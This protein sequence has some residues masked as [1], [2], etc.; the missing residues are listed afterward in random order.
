MKINYR[1]TALHWLK[2]P[3]TMEFHIPQSKKDWG[4][5]DARKFGTSMQLLFA[6]AVKAG[7]YKKKIR[8]I[9]TPFL[10]AFEKGK[11]ALK[12]VFDKEDID[13]SGTF[14]TQNGSWTST[15]FY[16]VRTWHCQEGNWNLEFSL[17]LFTKHA[18]ADSFGLDVFIMHKADGSTKQFLCEEWEDKGLDYGWWMGWL[19]AMICFIKYCPVETKF[20]DAGRREKHVGQKYV[21]ETK[22][23][24]EILDSTWFTNIVRSEGFQVGGHFRMQAFGKD[25]SEKRLIWVEPFEK[26]GY[27]RKARNPETTSSIHSSN[28]KKQNQ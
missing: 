24:I 13:E 4:L 20:V 27:T 6:T 15:Y 1:N 8:L 11:H 25:W 12:T 17:L 23:R 26:H 3:M 21:N 5:E 14:V 10:E 18:Q 7:L 28:N 22:E 19:I 9:S 2:D 16:D